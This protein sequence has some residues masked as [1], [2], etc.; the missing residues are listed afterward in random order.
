MLEVPV[1]GALSARVWV[2]SS[3]TPALPVVSSTVT[4]GSR[5][6][7]RNEDRDGSFQSEVWAVM[8][9]ALRGLVAVHA[10]LDGAMHRA[11]CLEN[12][13]VARR[14]PS[15]SVGSNTLSRPEA[16][17]AHGS[18]VSP[19]KV[20]GFRRAQLGPPAPAALA[21]PPPEYLAP[22]VVRGQPY[23]QAADV[24]AFGFALRVACCGGHV[25]DGVGDYGSA[26]SVESA[27]VTGN[28]SGA[29]QSILDPEAGPPPGPLRQSLVHLLHSMLEPDPSRRCSAAEVGTIPF[30]RL[31]GVM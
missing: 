30:Y 24:Y 26:V 1:E 18:P 4:D 20:Y 9:Q 7:T 29:G 12:I 21:Q 6:S 2:N 25:S 23:S 5:A 22:E 16:I 10:S 14:P 17:A 19:S 15:V 27:G 13:L 8:V 28:L 3:A 11:V 31:R